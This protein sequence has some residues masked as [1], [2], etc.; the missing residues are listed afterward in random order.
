[1]LIAIPG[2][3]LEKRKKVDPIA[4]VR[5]IALARILMP[6]SFV[7]LS[8]GPHGDERRDAGAVLLRR[9]QLDLLSAIRC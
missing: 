5:T 6:K 8:A 4:F 1:M 7:R 3:P 2:T 9:R